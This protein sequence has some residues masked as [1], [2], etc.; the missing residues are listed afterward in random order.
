MKKKWKIVLSIFVLLLLITGGT[1][2]YFFEMKEY[3]VADA[4]V[5]Q[6]VETEYDI[7][8]PG[9]QPTDINT[10]DSTVSGDN[11]QSTSNNGSSEDKSA[12]PTNGSEE[13][14]AGEGN[15]AN[16]S[17]N[18][19]SG[20]NGSSEEIV[21]VAS[22]KDKYRPSFENLQ[23]QA[24]AKINNLVSAAYSEYKSKKA[25]GE[26]IS[27]SYFYQKY[28]GAGASLESK[29]DSA[30]QI[31][32]SALQ[33][34]LKKQGFSPS[35]AKQFQEEYESAKAERESALLNKAKEAL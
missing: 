18:G 16:P 29:T 35:H 12:N 6:I 32:Y 10:E 24:D 27:F 23:N 28:K 17:T 7:V 13:T 30:F 4:E 21:T 15:N 2:Y 19:E 22:I 25:Q 20:N 9:D 34:E 11:N 1:I 3:E 14:P 8:L 33:D 31:I 26:S 5:E